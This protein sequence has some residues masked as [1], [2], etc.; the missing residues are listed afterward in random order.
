MGG[1]GLLTTHWTVQ[2]DKS[3]SFELLLLLAEATT[4][5][6]RPSNLGSRSDFQ[7]PEKE[8]LLR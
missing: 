3:P 2:S 5:R 4:F 6:L 8:R 1:D 7:V